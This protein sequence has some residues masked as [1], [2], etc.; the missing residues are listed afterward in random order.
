MPGH[1]VGF[2]SVR[3]MYDLE[4]YYDDGFTDAGVTELHFKDILTDA[5]CEKLCA[6]LSGEVLTWN[7]V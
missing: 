6:E 3:E 7:K 5:E 4:N 2:G 1:L